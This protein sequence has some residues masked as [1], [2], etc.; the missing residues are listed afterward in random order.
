M[1]IATLNHNL[2]SLTD[3]LVNQLKRDPF[4]EKCELVVVDNGSKEELAKSTTHRLEENVFFGGGFNVVLEYFLSTNHEYLYFLNND[5]IF[6]GPSF[7]TTSYNEAKQSDATV[8]SPSVINASI[9]QC[10]WKQ[11][12]NWGSGLREVDWVD[13]QCPLI[14]RRVLEQIK[15]YPNELIYG[16]GLDFYTGCITKQNNWKTIVSD[17]NTICHLNSQ[18]FKQNKIEIGVSEFCQQAD[19]RMN[20]FFLNSEFRDVYFELRKHGENYSI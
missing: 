3:N 10:H 11:M 6:H 8:Y 20:N 16:W 12:W 9:E 15:Q 18:T 14:H 13:F 7:L 4:F 19:S 1:L 17:T 5:L 2:A